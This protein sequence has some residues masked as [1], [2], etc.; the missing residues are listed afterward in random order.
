[1]F[2][3]VEPHFHVSEMEANKKMPPR[4]R[5]HFAGSVTEDPTGI[6][7]GNPSR[8]TRKIK[9]KPWRLSG[10]FFFSMIRN[11][12]SQLANVPMCQWFAE[13]PIL[14]EESV[15]SQ[16]SS[17]TTAI[18]SEAREMAFF[19]SEESAHRSTLPLA[20]AIQSVAKNPLVAATKC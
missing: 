5:W 19:G 7:T 11:T 10:L 9:K 2:A 14:S 20:S 3:A 16:H 18:L 8:I 6:I 4:Q 17:L 12:I 13:T 15:P 1:M